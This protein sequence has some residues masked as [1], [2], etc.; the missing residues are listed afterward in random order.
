MYKDQNPSTVE[1][2]EEGSLVEVEQSCSEGTETEPSG[3]FSE[4]DD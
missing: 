1:G 3:D 4:H 2:T